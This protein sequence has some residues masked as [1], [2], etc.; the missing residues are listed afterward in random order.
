MVG[1]VRELPRI[2][3]LS[4]Q[5]CLLNIPFSI[6]TG[7]K[8]ILCPKIIRHQ[9][10]R[11]EGGRQRLALTFH[12]VSSLVKQMRSLVVS[13]AIMVN[14]MDKRTHVPSVKNP[15]CYFTVST[16]PHLQ[17]VNSSGL[18]CFVQHKCV[19]SMK[20]FHPEH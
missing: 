19:F 2:V 14:L 11:Q 9:I 16:F 5:Q 3:L 8:A 6:V 17:W 7:L 15:F 12:S 13:V 20:D 18:L 1:V 10:E 4:Q